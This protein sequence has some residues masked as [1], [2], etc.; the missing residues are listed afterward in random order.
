MEHVSEEDWRRY[1]MISVAALK[2]H[3]REQRQ[4]MQEAIAKMAA[5]RY[6]AFERSIDIDT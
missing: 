4:A 5:M 2:I 3:Y 1:R 6:V